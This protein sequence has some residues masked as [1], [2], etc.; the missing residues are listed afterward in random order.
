VERLRIGELARLAGVTTRTI[1]HYESLGLIAPGERS[2]NGYRSYA[3]SALV[4]VAEIRRLRGLSMSLAAIATARR[5]EGDRSLAEHV[6]G[7][8]ADIDHEIESLRRRRIA[9]DE[10]EDALD[11]GEAILSTGE[12]PLFSSVVS[13]LV[14][15]EATGEAID[16]ARRV[17]AALDGL[18][19]PVE[20]WDLLS[21]GLELLRA[22]SQACAQWVEVLE[23]MATLRNV[24]PNDPAVGCVGARLAQLSIAGADIRKG[25][26]FDTGSSIAILGA[27][28]SCFTAGQIAAAVAAAK[29]I[30]MFA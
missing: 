25:L 29:Q 17:F 26:S 30:G 19:L 22:D 4:V 9:L 21:D 12:P 11:A 5:E 20:W 16:E 2:T 6:D 18:G 10:L 8:K 7:L 24:S 27:V 15:T 23:L 1:R 14:Q 28:A 3:P 13:L